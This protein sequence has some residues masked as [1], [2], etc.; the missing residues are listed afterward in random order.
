VYGL[1]RVTGPPPRRFLQLSPLSFDASSFDIWVPLLRG[2]QCVLF[3]DEAPTIDGIE[4]AIRRH[5]IECLWLTSALFN[6]IV[7]ERPAALGG[8]RE[9]FV[10]GEALSPP[11]IERA[12]KALPA[13]RLVNGY[14]PTEAA[15]FT[16]C[17]P[18]D[19]ASDP[20][21]SMPIGRRSRI[22]GCSFSIPRSR[23]R[24]LA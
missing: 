12:L 22:R 15:T 1:D 7:D 4:R 18:I 10:G 5:N 20:A 3:D 2:G 19:R 6:T 16:C 14:G 9:I 21:R 13:V 8:A 17:H 24:R 23:H 11:H